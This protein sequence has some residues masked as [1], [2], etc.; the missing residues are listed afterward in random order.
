[1]EGFPRARWW[2]SSVCPR[3]HG[4]DIILNGRLS[5]DLPGCGNN[6]WFRSC[7]TTLFHDGL[8]P[9]CCGTSFFRFYFYSRSTMLF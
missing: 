5:N 1:M 4:G 9:G 7:S 2:S 8:I 3:D 6:N